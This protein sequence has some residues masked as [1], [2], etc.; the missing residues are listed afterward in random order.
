MVKNHI[1]VNLKKYVK[2]HNKICKIKEPVEIISQFD[3]MSFIVNPMALKVAIS[4]LVDADHEDTSLNY[5]EPHPFRQK[6]L[7]AKVNLENLLRYVDGLQEK[8]KS[9]LLISSPERMKLR[10]E[11]FEACGQGVADDSFFLIDG[12][13]GIGKTLALMRFSLEI[14]IEQWEIETNN[15]WSTIVSRKDIS[16]EQKITM[17]KDVCVEI[18]YE[19]LRLLDAG[20][21]IQI[22]IGGMSPKDINIDRI[23]W[24]QILDPDRGL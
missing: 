2:I 19:K 23:N 5:G 12:T 21:G 15:Q 17:L 20:S 1:D 24:Q 22:S 18:A 11:F 14:F 8:C 9:G 7:E 16:D 3:A 10:Q 6:H 13:V 4:I